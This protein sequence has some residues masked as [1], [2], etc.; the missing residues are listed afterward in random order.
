MR[1][2]AV[3]DNEAESPDELSFRRDDIL[4]VL[5]VDTDGI[6]G[7]WLCQH[8]HSTGIAPANRLKVISVRLFTNLFAVPTFQNCLSLLVLFFS[9][10]FSF[11][12]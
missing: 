9:L 2:R 10:P 5:E 4:T 7:W 8:G 6:E 11:V 12:Q 1:V 3:Y